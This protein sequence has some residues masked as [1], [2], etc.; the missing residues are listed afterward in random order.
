MMAIQTGVSWYLIV[1]LI[2]TSL[3]VIYVKHLFMCL[4]AIRLA[5][6]LIILT[7]LSTGK[8]FCRLSLFWNLSDV[9]LMIQLE[10]WALEEDHRGEVLFSS[11]HITSHHIT[12]HHN[13]TTNH[14]HDLS[15]LMSIL[16]E[17]AFV[18]LTSCKVFFFSL[19]PNVHLEGGMHSSYL[20]SEDLWSLTLRLEYL[21]KLFGILLGRYLFSHLFIYS[22]IYLSIWTHRYLFYTCDN[23]IILCCSNCSIFGHGNSFT[24]LLCSFDR[25]TWMWYFVVFVLLCFLYSLTFCH[26]MFQAHLV[27]FF[28]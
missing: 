6:F 2:L 15:Q 17:V 27:Y 22:T 16:T 10:P 24:W 13:K 23:P 3:I 19:F 7:V 18:K 28:C 20:R 9:F 1:A 4:L 8:T 11:H 25:M 21:H 14:Q 5:L 12:S 26:Y